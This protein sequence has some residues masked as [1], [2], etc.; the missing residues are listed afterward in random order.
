VT[1]PIHVVPLGVVP[2]QFPYLERNLA[3]HSKNFRFLMF[4]DGDWSHHRKNFQTALDAFLTAFSEQG[5][6]IIRELLGFLLAN[7]GGR[8]GE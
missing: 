6:L 1:V 3:Q 7:F 8:E 2:E 4:A 5:S